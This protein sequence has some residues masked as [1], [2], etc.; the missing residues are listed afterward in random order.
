MNFDHLYLITPSTGDKFSCA[1]ARFMNCECQ[2]QGI[3]LLRE[4]CV[5]QNSGYINLLRKIIFGVTGYKC[6]CEP[7]CVLVCVIRLKMFSHVLAWI[8]FICSYG[9]NSMTYIFSSFFFF[10]ILINLLDSC[11][12]WMPI[13]FC[14]WDMSDYRWRCRAHFP[15]FPLFRCCCIRRWSWFRWCYASRC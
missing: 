11:F 7:T 2:F 9:S 8:Y 6:S 5:R 15:L 12:V 4:A 3:N 14:T 10:L 13:L 1:S